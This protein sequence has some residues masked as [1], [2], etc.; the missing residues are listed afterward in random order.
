MDF[1]ESRRGGEAMSIPAN[2]MK[3]HRNS[4]LK[5]IS[6]EKLDVEEGFIKVWRQNLRAYDE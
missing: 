4:G 2:L 6:W 3:L 1:C 5:M